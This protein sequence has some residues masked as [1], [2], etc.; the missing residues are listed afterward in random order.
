MYPSM[1][2]LP[3]TAL[4]RDGR[5]WW[6]GQ[7]WL[8]AYTPDQMWRFD[9]S[10]WRPANRSNRPPNWLVASGLVWLGLLVSWLFVGT[11]FLAVASPSAPGTVP[12]IIILSLAS[13]GLLATPTWGY[14]VGRRR[15]TKW[16]WPAAAIGSALQLAF[17]VTAMLAAPSTDGSEQDTA[18][19]AG[20]VILAI[21][22][23]LAILTLL[24][25]GAGLGALSRKF[26]G[27][28]SRAVS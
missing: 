4:S 27:S 6:N 17:Y 22:T 12:G 18:A 23:A 3:L 8:P 28:K 25:I 7:H 15:A 11:I 19:G 10:H 14:L 5:W 20:L 26:K 24:W 2:P 9:G 1:P 16:L 21:P 13:I